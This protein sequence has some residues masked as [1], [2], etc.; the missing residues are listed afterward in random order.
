MD[1]DSNCWVV[2]HW[3]NLRPI[4]KIDF[5]FRVLCVVKGEEDKDFTLLVLAIRGRII[6]YYRKCETWT[7]LRGL[8]RHELIDDDAYPFV[9]TL[10][11]F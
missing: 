6:S 1:R 11:A 9:E 5:E 7:V 4:E 2:K 8:G 10:F 3:F